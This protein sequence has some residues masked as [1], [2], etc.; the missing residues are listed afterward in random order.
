MSILDTLEHIRGA[1]VHHLYSEEDSW[2]E[3]LHQSRKD[4]DQ[5]KSSA[6]FQEE[7]DRYVGEDMSW[8][9]APRMTRSGA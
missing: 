2:F 3:E 5:G 4:V 8:E 6:R 9:E 7:F 1:V